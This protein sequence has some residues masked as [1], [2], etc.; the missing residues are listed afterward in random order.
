MNL[1]ASLKCFCSLSPGFHCTCVALSIFSTA[2][3]NSSTPAE[4]KRPHN[5]MLPSPNFT[6]KKRPMCRFSLPLQKAFLLNKHLT[7]TWSDESRT[8]TGFKKCLL[9]TAEDIRSNFFRQLPIN[10]IVKII[11]E[12]K[13]SAVKLYSANFLQLGLNP[14]GLPLPWNLVSVRERSPLEKSISD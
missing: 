3:M 6:I 12:I 7:T 2:L 5:M 1:N 9:Q 11:Y 10:H 14:S 13:F 4:G 8:C